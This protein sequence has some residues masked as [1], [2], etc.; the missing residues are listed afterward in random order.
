MWHRLPVLVRAVVSGG[1]LA[2]LGVAPWVLLTTANQEHFSVVPWAVLP[3]GLYL[4]GFWR[5]SGGAGWPAA[6]SA[7]RRT[8]R[9]RLILSEEVWEAA[10]LA[11]ILGLLTLV[12]A[13]RVIVRMVALPPQ[14]RPDIS[15]LSLF[16]IAGLLLMGSLVAGVVEE[17]SFRGYMQRPIE[18]RHGPVA[19]ILVTGVVFGFAHFSHPEV[20]LRLLPYYLGAAAVYGSLAHLTDSVLPGMFLHVVGNGFSFVHLFAGGTSQWQTTER[21][22]PLIW[23]SGTDVSFW[24]SLGATSILAAASVWAYGRLARVSRPAHP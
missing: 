5:Y 10:L 18:E 8:N 22:R 11:G 9:R 12:A 4:W 23:D 24:V 16:T 3:A 14:S 21:A 13:F 17:V 1:S 20:T 15:H 19:A 6:T 7:A 2:L